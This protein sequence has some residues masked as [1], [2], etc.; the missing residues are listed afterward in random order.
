[1]EQ[2]KEKTK[3]YFF[4]VFD[5]LHNKDLKNRLIKLCIVLGL[6]FLAELNSNIEIVA[7][8]T[9]L[10]FVIFEWSPSS[11]VWVCVAGFYSGTIGGTVNWLI[12]AMCIILAIRF[13]L[14]CMAK[15]VNFKDWKLITISILYVLIVLLMLLPLSTEYK[16]SSQFSR[17]PLFTL[18]VFMV[19][20]VKEI[21]IRD[22]LFISAISVVAGCFAL[23]LAGTCKPYE[24]G[25]KIQYSKGWV[26]RYAV[27]MEDPNF[28]GSI[29]LGGI[30]SAYILH[31]R[32]KI[33]CML[34]YILVAMLGFFTLRTLSKATM[35][36][37]GVLALYILIENIVRFIKTKNKQYLI[38][39]GVYLGLALIVCAI[40][41]KYVDAFVGRFFRNT[42]GWW[43]DSGNGAIDEI[44]TGRFSLWKMYLEEIFGS[45]R[46]FLF[47]AGIDSAL[48]EG[49]SAHSMP[50]TYVWKC[51]ALVC[52]MLLAITV[53]GCI[54][55]LKKC[56][57][58]N[59]IP[60]IIIFGIMCSLGS[61][62]N[63]YFYVFAIPFLTIVWD[64]V[65]QDEQESEPIDTQ[66]FDNQIIEEN[67]KVI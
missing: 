57:P 50:I 3:E 4:K 9:M 8:C 37:L 47:G 60:M 42:T 51:G 17:I 31:R 41:W 13:I 15:K 28:T 23:S 24:A 29:L 19:Y 25:F 49:C 34:Y 62:L 35:L 56:K 40:E 59:F 39:L 48:L 12:Y 33:N 65:E 52:L 18:I 55:Y 1:M 20:Y 22:L 30:A 44:T 46:I 32:E 16:F 61:T 63:R 67:K 14:E 26:N 10:A 66:N 36:M 2:A 64:G 5:F 27:F 54:P 38:E 11:I 6:T 21:N 43:S 45:A 7:K 58:Y 53:I